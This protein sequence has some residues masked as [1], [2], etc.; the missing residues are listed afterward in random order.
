MTFSPTTTNAN[1]PFGLR[2]I[3]YDEKLL[4]HACISSTDSIIYVNEP[5]QL[6]GGANA[7]AIGNA[8]AGTLLT[9]TGAASTGALFGSIVS[10]VPNV[11]LSQ[12]Q[13][14]N[15]ANTAAEVIICPSSDTSATYEIMSGDGTITAANIGKNANLFTPTT[16]STLT[17]LSSASLDYATIATTATLQLRIEQVRNS[18]DN[19]LGA[20]AIVQVK[21]N[22]TNNTANTAGI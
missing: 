21:I 5:V 10:I 14:W 15:P 17:G 6:A 2:P 20:N 19:V 22:N 1:A 12:S 7:T 18:V 11:N 9:V 8:P 16:G 3:K 4:V 13:V